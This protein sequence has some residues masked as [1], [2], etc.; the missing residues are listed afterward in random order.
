MLPPSIVTISL[1]HGACCHYCSQ[2]YSYRSY[3]LGS[4]SISFAGSTFKFEEEPI[5]NTEDNTVLYYELLLSRVRNVMF[6][7]LLIR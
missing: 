6:L 2:S 3:I 7:A 5:I 4:L 1:H